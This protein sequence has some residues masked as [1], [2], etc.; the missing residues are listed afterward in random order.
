LLLV[1]VVEMSV[2]KELNTSGIELVDDWATCLES[3]VLL[4]LTAE[5]AIAGLEV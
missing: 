4:G 5:A 2:F 1:T 3:T